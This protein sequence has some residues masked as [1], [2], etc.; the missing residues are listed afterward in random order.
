MGWQAGL[1]LSSSP[2]TST[3]TNRKDQQCPAEIARA[4]QQLLDAMRT[5][6]PD[7]VGAIGNAIEVLINAG[8]RIMLDGLQPAPPT[9]RGARSSCESNRTAMTR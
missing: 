2:V 3:G 5:A 7:N 6:N 9:V 1:I 8:A 4:Q